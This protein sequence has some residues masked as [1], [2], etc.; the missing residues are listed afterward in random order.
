VLCSHCGRGIR[1][2]LAVILPKIAVIIPTYNR[3]HV[4][5]RA[6]D[7]V[8]KQTYT[9][10]EL[11]VVDDGSDDNTIQVLESY[12]DRLRFFK[13]MNLGVSHARNFGI[14]QSDADWFALLDSDDEWLPE[15]LELQLQY[16]ERN[17]QFKIIHGEEIW[18]RN[19]KRVNPMKKHQKAGGWIFKH[20]LPLCAI[21]PSCVMI[22]KNVFKKVG[23]FN[24]NYP[25]CEDYDLWLRIT[26]YFE[27]GYIEDPLIKKYGGHQDQL[28]Q[29]FR[30]MDY[31][32]VLSLFA[33]K[34][35]SE[36]KG[37]EIHAL[38]E[39]FGQKIEILKAGYQKHRN[40]EK[41]KEMLKLQEKFNRSN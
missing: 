10:F 15:K 24:E 11:I 38:K 20:C 40:Q 18:I 5:G 16:L 2:K 36:L 7:S 26:P 1:F 4:L 31:W 35:C 33:M 21:S 41:F 39:I 27:V 34:D 28:S 6:I 23:Y 12:G 32:R 17:P 13:T 37:D 19:G 3:S 29:K 8:L 25:A 30:A 14:I 22:H 9:N